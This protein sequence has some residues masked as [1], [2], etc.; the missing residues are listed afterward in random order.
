MIVLY[1]FQSYNA[2]VRKKDEVN[3][4][5]MYFEPTNVNISKNIIFNNGIMST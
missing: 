1:F 5:G 4:M 2:K 3:V